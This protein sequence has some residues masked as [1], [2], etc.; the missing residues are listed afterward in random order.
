M[1]NS[2]HQYEVSHFALTTKDNLHYFPDSKT[3]ELY[4]CFPDGEGG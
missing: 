2:Q 1:S 3:K 4:A